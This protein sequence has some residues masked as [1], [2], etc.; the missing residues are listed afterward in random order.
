MRDLKDK[1]AIFS[2]YQKEKTERE[3]ERAHGVTL[4]ALESIGLGFSEVQGC[5]KYDDGTIESERSILVV[6]KDN[7]ALKTVEMICGDY[8]QECYLIS[9]HDRS[10]YLVYGDHRPNT[11]LG[12][13]QSITE[14][15]A[16]ELDA[17][18]YCKKTGYWGII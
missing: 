1:I 8:N 17:F 3:N 9:E 15:Q 2:V 10:S 11:D 13:L 7:D 16:K 18:T 12:T 4:N 6:L 14:S 5:Y